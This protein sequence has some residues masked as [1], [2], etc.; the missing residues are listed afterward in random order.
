MNDEFNNKNNEESVTR[1]TIKELFENWEDPDYK[2]EEF[3]WG[4]PVGDEV[5]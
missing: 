5:W 1:K 3:D 4:K 2:V